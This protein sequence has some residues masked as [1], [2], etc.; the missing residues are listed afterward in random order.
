M[1]FILITKDKE[2]VEAAREGFHPSDVLDVYDEWQ[3]GLDEAQDADLMFIDL[4]CT[5]EKP[6]EIQGYETFAHVKMA[7][8]AACAVPLVLISP[9]DA[10]KL[11]FMVGW[12][13]FL[14]GHLQRP[15][16]YRQFRRASTW[17]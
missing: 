2:L 16:D 8:P 11:D 5:L 13:N 15:L 12:P 6:H 3:T 7:H 10:Y 1:R 17:V 4:L 14:V 9:P